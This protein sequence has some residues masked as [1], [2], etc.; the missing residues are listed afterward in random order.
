MNGTHAGAGLDHR[1][2]GTWDAPESEML[3]QLIVDSLLRP[4]EA[5]QAVLAR[6]PPG[7]LLLQAA[8]VVTCLGMVLGYAAVE[9]GSG[10]VDPVS[11]ALVRDPLIGAAVQFV[12]M[13]VVA[14]LTWRVGGLFGGTGSFAGALTII[15][16][17][18]GV[19]LAIQLVQIVAMMIVPPVAGLVALAALFWLLWAFANFV[20]E[21]HG[22]RSPFVVL[23][24]SILTVIVL[25]FALSMVAAILGITPQGAQ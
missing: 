3:R 17:L 14:M 5:A 11:A 25:I 12:I 10:P 22:F 1:G 8:L 16:W 18:N 2:Q 4:R 13:L 21:L 23:G 24:V 6:V 7:A 20:V 19:M 9:I 15:V